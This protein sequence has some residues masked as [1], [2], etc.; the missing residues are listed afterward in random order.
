M[1][2][3]EKEVWIDIVGYEGIYQVSS[4]GSVKCP[5]REW[6]GYKGNKRVISNLILKS[7]DNGRGYL[8]VGLRK[9][10]HQRM[11]KVHRLVAEA[12]ILNPLNK[13]EVN[14]I[15]GVKTD[16][17]VNNL[18]WITRS[19]NQ[20]HAVKNGLC[21]NTIDSARIRHSKK[22]LNTD[23]NEIY[24]TVIDAALHNGIS[25]SYLASMLRGSQPNKTKL[26][27]V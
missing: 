10:N 26:I 9:N 27:Y 22:V 12:F 6:L 15:N 14:H 7:S 16:N 24:S 5:Y 2:N 13:K 18:E 1:E 11:E 21:K 19:E 20:K 4:F 17:H 23:T 25:K 8:I 3:Q